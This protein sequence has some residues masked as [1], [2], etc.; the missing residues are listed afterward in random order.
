MELFTVVVPKY[1]A[2]FLQE[3]MHYSSLLR[4]SIACYIIIHKKGM[5]VHYSFSQKETRSFVIFTMPQHSF[6]RPGMPKGI[7]EHETASCHKA[8]APVE[9]EVRHT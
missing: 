2:G 7:P 5:F 3:T 8:A 6:T 1:L 9:G 4:M